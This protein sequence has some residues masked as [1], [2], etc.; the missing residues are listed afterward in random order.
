MQCIFMPFS[1]LQ[2]YHKACTYVF[3]LYEYLH[4]ITKLSPVLIP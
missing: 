2:K 3:L 4:Q 1:N